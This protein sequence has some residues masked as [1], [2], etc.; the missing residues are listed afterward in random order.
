VKLHIAITEGKTFLSE[1]GKYDRPSETRIVCRKIVI[2][3][4]RSFLSE[5]ECNEC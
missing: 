2:W 3:K 4:I 1:I 5:L